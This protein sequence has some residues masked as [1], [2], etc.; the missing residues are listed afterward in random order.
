[1]FITNGI[2][3]DKNKN[4]DKDKDKDKNKSIIVS[5]EYNVSNEY[6]NSNYVND[7]INKNNE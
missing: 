4:K 2:I 1:M 6:I 3:S 5:N 7:E